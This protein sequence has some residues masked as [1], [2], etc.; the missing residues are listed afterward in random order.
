MKK[1]YRVFGN[2]NVTVSIIVEA[3]S[4]ED[5]IEKAPDN[6]GGICSYAGNGGV[7]KLIGVSRGV[8]SIEADGDVKFDDA[9]EVG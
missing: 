8:E 1:K 9:E 2:T 3:D 4:A 7:D 5:A 6:F